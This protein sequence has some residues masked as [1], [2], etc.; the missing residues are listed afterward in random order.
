MRFGRIIEHEDPIG[1][2]ARFDT[3][4]EVALACGFADQS[5]FTR[6]FR[7]ITGVTPG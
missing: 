7:A 2:A 5:H 6:V 3:N 4:Y 1:V